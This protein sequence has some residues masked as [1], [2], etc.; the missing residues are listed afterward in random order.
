[1]LDRSFA[2]LG[3]AEMEMLQHVWRLGEATV[4]DVYQQVLAERNV[5]YNTVLSILSKL[6]DKGTS[7]VTGRAGPTSIPPSDGPRRCGA[8]SWRSSSSAWSMLSSLRVR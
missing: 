7:V 8:A 2:P 5:S 4:A 3:E 6:T 1:M